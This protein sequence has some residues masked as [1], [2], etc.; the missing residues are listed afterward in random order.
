[1]NFNSAEYLVFLPVVL[2]L[3]GLLSG[4]ER[5]RH[6]LLLAASYVFYMSWN[7]Q[8]A[9]LIAFSTFVD[10]GLGRAMDAS[11][12]ERRRRALLVVSLTTNLGLLAVFKYFNFF[13]D[14][15]ESAL[16]WLGL[17]VQ[18]PHHRLLLP[19]GI[20]FYTFQTLSYTID[21]YRRQIEV[22]RSLT[23]FAL[24]VSFF[25]QLVAGPIVRASEFL[26]QLSSPRTVRAEQVRRGVA[27]IFR[28]LLKKVLVADL[29]AATLV[30]PAFADP[31]SAASLDLV[32]GLYAYAF[33]IYADFSGYSDIAIGTA[34]CL[35]YELPENFNRPYLSRNVR[36][37]WTRWHISLSS[38]L[39]DY[40][41]IPLGGNRGTKGRTS[42]NLMTTMVLG[43]LWHGAA[44]NFLLWGFYHGALLMFSRGA[45][46]RAGTHTAPALRVA[47]ERLVCFH[48]VLGGWLLFRVQSM[49]QL[50]EF[51]SGVAA[52]RGGAEARPAAAALLLLAAAV[53]LTPR[54][55]VDRAQARF[56]D[57]AP[58]ALQGAVYAGLVLLLCGA[59]LDTSAFIYFQF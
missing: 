59:T 37:F 22:E 14:S 54:A 18:V 31:S 58:A 45:D 39:R 56:A 50:G 16:T 7:W 34:L 40:L 38:W 49:E 46:R 15:A 47:W 5:G 41:Y 43:G 12:D 20:S 13:A 57:A 8:Y 17:D 9:S 35:G 28:G 3:H 51:L 29:L 10:Y 36:E 1:V 24:F 33:Q 2:L 44:A 23:R 52:L 4:R 11:E 21:L 26:P 48:L 53:H 19:V 55:L 30:D 25:P 6:W 42:F 27:R 32:L